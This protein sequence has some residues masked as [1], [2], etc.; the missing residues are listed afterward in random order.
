M[1]NT[2]KS[3]PMWRAKTNVFDDPCQVGVRER[4]S[5]DTG[6][7]QTNN[8]FRKCGEPIH[9][10]CTIDQT[11]TYPKVWGNVHQCNTDVDSDLRY[12]N[13]T[14][15]KNIQQLYNRPYLGQGYRGPGS[16]ALSGSDME[17][18]LLQGQTTTTYKPCEGGTQE[19]YIDRWDYLPG[20]PQMTPIT[21]EHTVEAWTRGGVNT[22]DLVRRMNYG[23][24]CH[25][26]TRA[27]SY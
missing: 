12:S 17:S 11:F 18:N 22:R 2:E 14:N 9:T 19:A 10:D 1:G 6:V 27:N 24:Y 16:N 21:L 8:F 23:D 20:H 3:C 5:Q 7:Y 13:L 25:T 26:L 15:L 4:Q